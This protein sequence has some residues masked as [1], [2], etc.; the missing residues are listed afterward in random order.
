MHENA[1]NKINGQIV[2][3]LR[4]SVVADNW[5]QY[6]SFEKYVDALGEE[7]LKHKGKWLDVS[8]VYSIF[9]DLLSEAVA[10]KANDS[11]LNGALWHLL[12]EQDAQALANRL[13]EYF[14]SIPRDYEIYAP[15]PARSIELNPVDLSAGLS[16]VVFDNAKDVPG[17]IGGGLLGML[18]K[19]LKPKK[20]YFRYKISG[21]AGRR[22][23]QSHTFRAALRVFKIAFQQ[24]ISKNLFSTGNSE[25][26]SGLSFL[27]SQYT[28]SKAKLI[29]VDRAREPTKEVAAE[30]AIDV[31]RLIGGL[32]LNISEKAVADSIEN[33]RLSETI[34][35]FLRLPTLLISNTEPEAERIR[36][37]IEWCFDSYATESDTMAFLQV[38]FGLEALL[39][40]ESG[41]E[42]L[43][44]TLA[45]RCAYLVGSDIKGRN[46][47]R[48]SFK[49]LYRIRSKLVHGTTTWLDADQRYYLR[50]GRSI[51]EFAIFK[52]IRHLGMDA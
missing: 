10:K 49:E 39:G 28:I 31:S 36:S 2:A 33:D 17:G 22:S 24:G 8:D 18:D 43:T 13:L 41:N 4:G 35:A 6:E 9:Y 16:I 50:W 3:S 1:K 25:R 30:L 14:L 5:P 15:F 47:I 52:E 7:L 29:S 40:E 44:S 23:V 32:D 42:S 46:S 48:G 26:E 21:Y 51:L 11:K 34:K 37:A 20:A 27:S 12:G 38:C 19:E 45:D